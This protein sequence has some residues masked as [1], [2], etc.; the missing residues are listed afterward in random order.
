MTDWR[1]E[2]PGLRGR[3]YLN[4]AAG[5]CMGRTVAGALHQY[6]DEKLQGAITPTEMQQVEADCRRRVAAFIGCSAGEIALLSSTTECVNAI[7]IGLPWEAGDNLVVTDLEF[8]SSIIACLH[9]GRRFGVEVRLVRHTDGVVAPAAI[10]EHVDDRTRLVVISHVSYRS[11]YRADLD[12]VADCAHAHG[13]LLLVD[14]SQSVGAVPLEVGAVDFIAACTRKWLLATHGLAFL[15]CRQDRLDVLQ[16]FYAGWRGTVNPPS[17]IN[18]LDYTFHDDARRFE[19]GLLD[20]TAVY[21]LYAA[22]GFLNQVGMPYITERVLDLSGQVHDVLAGLGITPLTPR[23]PA[24]RAGIVSFESPRYQQIGDALHAAGVHVWAKEGR[25]RISP[26]FYNA[27]TDVAACHAA[28][29]AAQA[30]VG[31]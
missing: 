19:T 12:A 16:P 10:A 4:T 15:Y 6:T 31:V 2:F 29:A 11:G 9:L 17:V 21:T 1:D 18:T 24:Q 25:V 8:P 22:L 27:D 14:A 23:D 5:S 13:A 20:Y 7:L 26:H 3:T 30:G 28:L